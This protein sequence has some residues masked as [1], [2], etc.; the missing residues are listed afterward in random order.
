MFDVEQVGAAADLFEGDGDGALVVVGLDQAAEPR[1]AGDVGAL[2]DHDEAGVRADLERLE[3]AEPSALRRRLGHRRG[4]QPAT[5]AAIAAM[6]AG[7]VP[8]QPPTMLTRPARGE[9]ADQRGGLV[10]RLVVAAERVRQ[11]GVGVRGD[12]HGAMRGQLG[13]V[14]AHLG[15]RRASS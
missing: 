13:H 12:E 8:Q 2:A 9:L 1:R 14:R 3:A 4:A 15:R 11:P 7:V 6:W 10:G 5:A